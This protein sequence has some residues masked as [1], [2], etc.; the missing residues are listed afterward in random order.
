M[1]NHETSKVCP[2]QMVR[3]GNLPPDCVGERC[4]WFWAGHCA[5]LDIAGLNDCCGLIR[6]ICDG[7]FSIAESI[8]K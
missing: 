5:V 7:L 2:F 8:S 6:G 1:S 3:A 4:A